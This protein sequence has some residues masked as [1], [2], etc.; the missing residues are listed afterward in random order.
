MYRVTINNYFTVLQKSGRITS[1]VLRHFTDKDIAESF[2]TIH[3]NSFTTATVSKVPDS[4]AV[5]NII[6]HSE[7]AQ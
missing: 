6:Y 1:T 2:A 3:N 4:E 7:E 5:D